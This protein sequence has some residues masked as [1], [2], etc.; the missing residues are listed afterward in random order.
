MHL[1]SGSYNAYIPIIYT[2]AS[3]VAALMPSTAPLGDLTLTLTNR[4]YTSTPV[5]VHVV[6]SSFGIFTL[7]EG[8][9]GQAIVQNYVNPTLQ[10]V[11]TILAPA[12][13]GGVGILWGTGLGPVASG[14]E[15]AGPIPGALPYLDALYVGGQKVNVRYA[16]RT[17]CC[18]GVDQ[19][20]FDVP[21]GIQGCYVPVAAVVNGL[22]SNVATIAIGSGSTCSDPLS[23]NSS[24]LTTL[25]SAGTLSVGT[26][27]Y[28]NNLSAGAEQASANFLDYTS[29]ALTAAPVPLHATAGSCYETQS[30]L[31]LTVQTPSYGTGLNAGFA[32]SLNGPPGRVDMINNTTTVG[33]YS[34][35]VQPP[36][37]FPGAYSVTSIGGADIGVLSG[38]FTAGAPLQWTNSAAYSGASIPVGQQL[39]FTWT[40]GDSNTYVQIGV[41]TSGATISTSIVCNLPSTFGSFTD[42]RLPGAHRPARKR[43]HLARFV[44]R[45]AWLHRRQSRSR[46]RDRGNQHQRD[47]EF[48]ELARPLVW[49]G[50]SPMPLSFSLFGRKMEA[51][52]PDFSRIRSPFE[53]PWEPT[54]CDQFDHAIQFL[55]CYGGACCQ[56]IGIA[57]EHNLA[58]IGKAQLP[59]VDGG[60]LCRLKHDGTDKVIGHHSN[61]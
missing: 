19:I 23:F 11:N 46:H 33:N 53:A 28:W 36:L 58:G 29:P 41:L 56:N 7:N 5:S 20:N 27:N 32:V 61:Q 24:D 10:P 14:D 9:T 48:P 4:T 31:G 54:S 60:P 40:P 13:P 3:Q 44:C 8:G 59:R 49:A 43:H 21:A 57:V 51:T 22:V 26:I 2:S 16:G 47:G 35:T 50:F 12:S 39:A 17:S 38:S 18:A 1:N 42:T 15:S 25:G 6:R 34:A 45:A 55:F 37:T 30:P 52:P